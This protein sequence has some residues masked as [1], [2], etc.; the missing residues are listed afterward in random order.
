[1]SSII[2]GMPLLH[3]SHHGILDLLLC[4]PRCLYEHLQAVC[5]AKECWAQ[6]PKTGLHLLILT[7]NYI[8]PPN[9]DICECNGS[10][11]TYLGNLLMQLYNPCHSSELQQQLY[12]TYAG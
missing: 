9:A 6:L 10:L 7:C 3:N 5:N 8:G 2:H 4:I 12:D 11:T 1:M